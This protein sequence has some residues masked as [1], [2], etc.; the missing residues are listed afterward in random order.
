[1]EN[2]RDTLHSVG[3]ATSATIYSEQVIPFILK[4][5]WLLLL[6]IIMVS[7]DCW[8]GISESKKRNEE[9]RFSGAGW[10]TLRKLLDYYTLLTLG[11]VIGHI[12]P[13]N[14]GL[15]VSETCFYFILIPSFFDLCSI[16][17]HIFKLKGVKVSPRQFLV[18][19]LVSFVKTKNCDMGNALEHELNKDFN[20]KQ[21]G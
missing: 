18:N 11:F 15:T 20:N 13:D 9:V 4:A 8:F 17:G 3:N 1:M 7:V 2:L 12:L 5:S 21:D 10:K 19:V 14:F 6:P 16:I